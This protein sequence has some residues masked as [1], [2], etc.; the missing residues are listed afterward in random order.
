MKLFTSIIKPAYA[1]VVNPIINNP[2]AQ[3]NDPKGYVNSVL[4]T[5]ISIFFIVA[6][7]Y[8][9]WHFVMS[10]YRMINSDG[11][12]KK[13]EEARRATI[14]AFVGLLLVFA[15]FAVLKFVGTVLGIEGLNLLKLTW[16]S[17]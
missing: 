8:F 4:Q 9:L 12:P 11:D 1:E 2:E 7:I 13:L 3:V 10:G 15:V 6:I 16:P 14:N 5:V 17:L